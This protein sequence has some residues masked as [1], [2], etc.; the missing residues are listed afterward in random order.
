VASWQQVAWAAISWLPQQ[1]E[2]PLSTCSTLQLQHSQPKTC[3]GGRTEP[4]VASQIALRKTLQTA[5]GKNMSNLFVESPGNLTSL[6]F[7]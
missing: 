2:L 4:M 3:D 6:Y 7:T 1:A 5:A